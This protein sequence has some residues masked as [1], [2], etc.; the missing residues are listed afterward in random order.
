MTRLSILV[1]TLALITNSDCGILQ[2]MFNPFGL[3]I[4]RN[5]S[6]PRVGLAERVGNRVSSRVDKVQDRVMDKMGGVVDKMTD[7][8]GNRLDQVGETLTNNFNETVSKGFDS[9]T[10]LPSGLDEM[11]NGLK[12]FLPGRLGQ[13]LFGDKKDKNEEVKD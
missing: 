13:A 9:L 12:R 6:A 5:P 3:G 10:K 1:I 4:P 2:F 11:G 7:R 8:V